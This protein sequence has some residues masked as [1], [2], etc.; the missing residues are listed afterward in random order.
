MHALF[1][2]VLLARNVSC[3]K[4]MPTILVLRYLS[5]LSF[6]KHPQRHLYLQ[7]TIYKLRL[8]TH[9]HVLSFLFLLSLLYPR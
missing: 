9:Y 5:L 4:A 2:F 3:V 1:L 6:Y 8:S 7:I